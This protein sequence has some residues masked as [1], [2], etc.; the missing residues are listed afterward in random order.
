MSF[1]IRIAEDRFDEFMKAM[2]TIEK[3]FAWHPVISTNKRLIWLK[4]Y[5]AV[6]ALNTNLEWNTSIYTR[7]EFIAWKLT[8]A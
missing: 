8:Q 6:S 4:P 5:W 3:K 2:T 7:E 1:E